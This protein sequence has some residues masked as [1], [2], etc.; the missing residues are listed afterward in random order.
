MFVR[1]LPLLATALLGASFAGAQTYPGE[2]PPL[3]EPFAEFP[4]FRP[5]NFGG[6][7]L[8]EGF[9]ARREAAGT[10]YLIV[11]GRRSFTSQ[12]RLCA[13]RWN[14]TTMTL[15]RL[16]DVD[17]FTLDG[18]IEVSLS[19]DLLDIIVFRNGAGVETGTRAAPN[20]PFSG[21]RAITGLL[22]NSYAVTLGQVD[23]G[24]LPS[25]VVYAATP[26]PNSEINRYQYDSATAQAS[27]RRLIG[28]RQLSG[29]RYELITPLE[30]E[31]GNTKKLLVARGQDLG[32]LQQ[33]GCISGVDGR[34]QVKWSFDAPRR[35]KCLS[36]VQ[37]AGGEFRAS[38]LGHPIGE[39]PQHTTIKFKLAATCNENLDRAGGRVRFKMWS[40][41]SGT[42]LIPTVG[43]I[44]LGAPG[45]QAIP[46]PG[47]GNLGLHPSVLVPLPIQDTSSGETAWD[48]NYPP[49]APGVFFWTQGVDIGDRIIL[50]N[51]AEA[52]Q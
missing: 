26:S 14:P 24:L 12:P 1:C 32:D 6:L 41:G 8:I 31:L 10:Y 27:G 45:A 21:R 52:L 38:I 29:N 28:Q 50:S 4:A 33:F 46:L 22:P 49:L 44:L 42:R 2:G 47:I 43:T 25:K 39:F 15:T 18:D 3:Y 51:T 48:L 35:N 16:T 30:D 23:E 13:W 7:V 34:S 36:C 37:W 19:H 9:A 40:P 20:L 5:A 11:A 17:A